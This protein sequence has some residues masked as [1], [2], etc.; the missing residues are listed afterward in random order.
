MGNGICNERRQIGFLRGVLKEDE[1]IFL[2]IIFLF[3]KINY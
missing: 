2:K 3:T 1:N